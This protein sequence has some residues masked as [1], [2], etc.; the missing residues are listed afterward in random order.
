MAYGSSQA[1]GLIG[2]VA[3]AYTTATANARSKLRL[4]PTPELTAMPDP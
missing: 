1:R 4:R 2:A 3:D